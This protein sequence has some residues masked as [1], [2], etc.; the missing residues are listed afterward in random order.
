MIHIE[1]KPD[2]IEQEILEQV[3]KNICKDFEYTL[4][5][6]V[7]IYLTDDELLKINQEF[8][9]HDYY[10]DVITFDLSENEK[11]INGEI[12]IS[13][14]RVIDNAKTWNESIE[15]EMYRVAIHGVLHLV[16][17]KDKTKK[18]EENIRNKENEYLSQINKR[19]TW[20]NGK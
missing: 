5:S 16:G 12:Y 6:V 1:N 10:T 9:S 20:N 3:V 18:E 15:S 13:H 17:L 19:S 14:E 4:D 7:Y 8:L 2:Y 11:T